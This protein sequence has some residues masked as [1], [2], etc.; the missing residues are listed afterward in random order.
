[1][2]FF[3]KSKFERRFNR[4][5]KTVSP[6]TPAELHQYLQ[7]RG[8]CYTGMF[9]SDHRMIYHWDRKLSAVQ[10]FEVF[11]TFDLQTGK[12]TIDK[13]RKKDD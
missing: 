3:L 1:M 8:W 13:Y 6:K 9:E 11:G 12:L 10:E 4:D 2:M 5:I 7:S